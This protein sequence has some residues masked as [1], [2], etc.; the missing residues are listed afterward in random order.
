MTRPARRSR[1]M[2]S[3]PVLTSVRSTLA[4]TASTSSVASTIASRSSPTGALWSEQV[5][6]GPTAG[7]AGILFDHY[8]DTATNADLFIAHAAN[9]G[10]QSDQAP[11]IFLGGTGLPN[12]SAPTYTTGN[13]A[14]VAISAS[15]AVLDD[16]DTSG[17]AARNRHP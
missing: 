2:V 4:A 12:F 6:G 1:W 3:S 11:T 13:A 17:L 14:G 8:H 5:T 16:P 7:T 15:T 10:E 9:T